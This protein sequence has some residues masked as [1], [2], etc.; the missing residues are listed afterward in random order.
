MSEGDANMLV[1]RGNAQTL[2][3]VF[4]GLK[5]CLKGTQTCCLRGL[6]HKLQKDDLQGSRHVLRG[7]K[8]T[9]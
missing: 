1:E 3:D 8:N 5:T 2:K 7:R 4:T 6:M 9:R